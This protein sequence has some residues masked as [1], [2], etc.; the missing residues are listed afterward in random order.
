M[1]APIQIWKVLKRIFWWIFYLLVS[2]GILFDVLYI[3]LKWQVI[4]PF[5][6]SFPNQPPP[7]AISSIPSGDPY[8]SLGALFSGIALLGVVYTLYFQAEENKRRANE[9]KERDAERKEDDA[10]RDRLDKQRDE[11]RLKDEFE[12]TFFRLVD[13][14]HAQLVETEMENEKGVLVIARLWTYCLNGIRI[15]S[16]RPVKDLIAS[17]NEYFDRDETLHSR[18]ATYFRSLYQVFKYLKSSPIEN[19]T[20]YSDIV[21]ALLSPAELKFLALNGVAQYGAKFKPLVED[22]HLLKHIP[23]DGRAQYFLDEI[24]KQYS[25]SARKDPED[26]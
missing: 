16:L 22:F 5:I 17:Y 12:R 11:Q 20:T 15:K 9:T 14:W 6:Y 25:P 19:K 24:L 13:T 1:N 23:E 4:L 7:S 26:K 21:R 18:M 3:L 2:I 8:T 10:R